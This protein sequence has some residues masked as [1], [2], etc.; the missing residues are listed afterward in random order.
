MPSHGAPGYECFLGAPGSSAARPRLADATLER[1]S[2]SDAHQI[3]AYLPKWMLGTRTGNT[4]YL[5]SRG[6]PPD[7]ASTGSL[8]AAIAWMP[9]MACLRDVSTR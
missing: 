9:L 4:M 3:R 8:S 1:G 7:A 2:P 5:P 6:A